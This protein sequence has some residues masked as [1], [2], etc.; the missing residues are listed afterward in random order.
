MV[1]E[2]YHKYL[3][4]FN[5]KKSEQF[6]PARTWDHK[7][8]IKPT[9]E[10]KAFKLY[11]LSFVKIKKQEKFVKENLWKGYIKHSKS[12]MAL[13][14]FFVAKKDRKLWLCQDYYYL[15]KH[16]IKNVYLIPNVQTILDKLCRSKYFTAM[17]VWLGYNNIHIQKQ[18]RWKGAFRTNQGLFEP[19]V[20]FFGIC[21]SSATFQT[22]MNTI[23]ALLIAKNLILVYVDNILIY[24]PTKKQLYKMTKEVLKIL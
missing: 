20:M 9:F 15:N 22:M 10:P 21:N 23:F 19:T 17:D 12:L 4:L 8:E 16:T 18:D 2:E 7:I 11:K 13:P 5:E 24:A 14:F 1:L 3:S 6:P